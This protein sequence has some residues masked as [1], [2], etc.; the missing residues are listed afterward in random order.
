MRLLAC[1]AVA[2]MLAACGQTQVPAH[3]TAVEEERV[4]LARHSE[5][6]AFDYDYP[7][8]LERYPAL[9][10]L[11]SGEVEK[12]HATYLGYA[13]EDR[14]DAGQVEGRS[15]HS[16]YYHKAWVIEAELPR[17]LSL[18]ARLENFTGGAHGNRYFDALVWDKQEGRALQAADLFT[19]LA[20][21]EAVAG[22]EACRALNAE[23]RER[24]AEFGAEPPY[25]G[26]QDCPAF[27]EVAIV[28]RSASGVAFDT[29]GFLYAPYVAGPYVEG[30]YFTE[31]PLDEAMVEAVKPEYR[32][33]FS[34]RH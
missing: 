11:L 15:F 27:D 31:L 29:V 13:E 30:E 24:R 7:A 19:S 17:F 4:N 28:P 9:V 1:L 12:D 26:A 20:A 8:S 2:G 3:A 18:S 22:P 10:A 23:R 5:L 14:D 32:A 21:F 16:H 6:L 33:F 34:A 25:E